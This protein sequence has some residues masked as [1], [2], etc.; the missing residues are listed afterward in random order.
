MYWIEP[1][2]QFNAFCPYLVGDYDEVANELSAYLRAGCKTCIIDSPVS[3]IE[4]QST[5]Q[6]FNRAQINSQTQ[7]QIH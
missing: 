6:V 5:Y 1:F 3:E 7:A 2:E 4:L